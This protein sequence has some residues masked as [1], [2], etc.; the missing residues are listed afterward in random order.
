MKRDM[1]KTAMK[2]EGQIDR[3]YNMNS[4]EWRQLSDMATNEDACTAIL[5]AFNYGYILGGRACKAGKFRENS[6]GKGKA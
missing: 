1:M 5:I 4:S 3:P 2:A 6:D